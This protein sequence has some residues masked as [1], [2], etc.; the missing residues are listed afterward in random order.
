MFIIGKVSDS[1]RP[2]ENCLTSEAMGSYHEGAAIPETLIAD[3]MR[4][5]S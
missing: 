5:P 3:F 4:K 2:R 1:V